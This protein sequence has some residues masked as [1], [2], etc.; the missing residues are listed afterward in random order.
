MTSQQSLSMLF[1]VA[2]SSFNS[3]GGGALTFPSKKQNKIKIQSNEK[4]NYQLC[5][6]FISA[7]NL[8]SKHQ[9]GLLGES[10][11]F[12]LPHCATWMSKPSF[13]LF[14]FHYLAK[15]RQCLFFKSDTFLWKYYFLKKKIKFTFIGNGYVVSDGLSLDVS[16]LAFKLFATFHLAD[17]LSLEDGH[18][19][20][21]VDK[22]EEEY[23]EKIG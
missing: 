20:I 22:L 13:S 18:V 9:I 5:F 1:R 10:S 2:S 14:F 7:R 8:V 16:K 17:E 23:F 3:R 11:C 21:Q 4:K 6:C 15:I 19:R 12:T